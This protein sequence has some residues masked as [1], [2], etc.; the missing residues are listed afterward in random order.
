M[1]YL[2]QRMGRPSRIGNV[3][4]NIPASIPASVLGWNTN[5]NLAGMDPRYALRLDNYL[6]DGTSLR[7]RR[8]SV[9]HA[10]GFPAKVEF[11]HVY[12]RGQ[13]RKL[14]A[15]SGGNVYDASGTGSIGAP[16]ATGFASSQFFGCNAGANGG[17]LGLYCNGSDAVQ[18]YDGTTFTSAGITGPTKPI[19][20]TVSKKRVW[21]IE[22]GT[23]EAWYGAPEQVT[24]A[25]TKFD[26][27]SVHPEGG[28]LIAIV[29]AT[30][31][32]GEG[33]DDLTI[34]AMQS[35]ALIVYGGTDPGDA[36]NWYLK[37][38]WKGG[39]PINQRCFV[40]FE[41]DVAYISNTGI[42]TLSSYTVQGKLGGVPL[43][44]KINN[45]V[46]RAI[47][48]RG[49]LFEWHGTFYQQDR[50]LLINMPINSTSS[51]QAVMVSPYRTWSRFLG[52][53]YW[54][55]AVFNNEL[56]MGLSDKIVRSSDFGTDSGVLV[57]GYV[58]TAWNY[59]GT[60]GRE[61]FFR[62]FRVHFKG[63]TGLKYGAAVGTDFADPT[64]IVDATLAE[65][66]ARWGQDQWRVGQW[67]TPIAI[68]SDW[69]HAAA[70]GFN[71]SVA[72]STLSSRPVEILATDFINELGQ[73]I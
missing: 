44:D 51:E 50:L 45:Y 26:I 3:P 17:E 23:G 37:G 69:R 59:F 67:R 35:G 13:Q 56:H 38:V 2:A 40:P 16:L 46:S 12:A 4:E 39:T 22:F 61:K 5:D 18:K 72:V 10:T 33:P 48:E 62:Q 71:A 68:S 31:D 34:F 65:T 70:S 24:G 57:P 58:Q 8:G 53:D 54:S 43:S 9:D 30:L 41:E 64:A 15:F 28:E 32:G 21:L 73:A 1:G 49:N 6:A 52:L 42:R 7:M 27:G 60:R 63:A 29:N 20:I 36:A 55:S 66:A 11:L 19:G 47:R 14:L 25:L